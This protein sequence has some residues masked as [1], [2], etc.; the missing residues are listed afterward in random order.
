MNRIL[1]T[2]PKIDRFS[3]IRQNEIALKNI[4]LRENTK[5]VPLWNTKNF[6]LRSKEN[7]KALF[8]NKEELET[9]TSPIFLSDLI[10]LGKAND[11][12]YFSINLANL[13]LN[14]PLTI[15]KKELLCEELRVYGGNLNQLDSSFLALAKGMTF[16][17]MTHKFCGICG[18]KTKVIEAGFVIK[19]QNKNCNLSH[20]PRTDPAII[21]LVSF[22]NEILLA[23][24]PRFP[25]RMYSTL[26]GFVEPGET[27]EQAVEREV[28]EEVGVKVKNIKYFDSQPWPFPASLMLGFFAVAENKKIKIDYNEIQDAH[29]FS[30]KNLN[31]LNHPNISSGFKLPRKDSIARRLVNNWI[32]NNKFN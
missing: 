28:F 5:F 25:E 9:V 20:F 11:N 29:W 2:S 8:L 15:N 13:I 17:Q 10:F 26:A 32:K 16:W 23:R 21:T 30:Y 31:E 6:F 19:C 22:K 24:S 12:Y 3:E 4:L 7:V 18:A 1:Y 27:L 14:I